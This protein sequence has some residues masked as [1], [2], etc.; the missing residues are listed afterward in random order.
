MPEPA[1]IVLITG[2]ARRVG[3]EIARQVA[4]RGAKI[5]LHYRHSGAEAESLA[6]DLRELYGTEVLTLGGDLR[7]PAV[8]GHLVAQILEQFG[9]LDG[10]VHNASLY[11]ST[12]LSE[13]TPRTWENMEGIHVHAPFYLAQAAEM[14]LR[15]RKGAIVHIADIYAERP[16]R[17]YLPYSVSKA[18]LIALTRALAKEMAPEVRVNSISPGVI[19][20]AETDLPAEGDRQSILDRTAL[21]RSGEPADIASMVCTLLFDAP[22]LTGQN[23][24]VDGGRMLY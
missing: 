17:N 16:L 18:A 15:S 23:I 2:A 22:Y 6:R 12:P 11:Q 13:I 24:V 10:I 19:L 3:S 14:V 8:P 5:A 4:G 20:W 7:D 1:K 9:G 21:K